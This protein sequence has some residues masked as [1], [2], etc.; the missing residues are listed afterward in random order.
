MDFDE[1]EFHSTKR[2]QIQTTLHP[3]FLNLFQSLVPYLFSSVLGCFFLEW[4]LLR[5]ISNQT[6]KTV[7]NK[8]A[9]TGTLWPH[10]RDL[11]LRGPPFFLSGMRGRTAHVSQKPRAS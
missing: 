3:F 7:D 1:L 10:A 4:T 2:A 5:R 6:T 9:S 8:K 11:T